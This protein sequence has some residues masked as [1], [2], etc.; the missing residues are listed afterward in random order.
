MMLICHIVYTVEKGKTHSDLDPPII[1]DDYT[2]RWFWFPFQTS[3]Q[4]ISQKF[5]RILEEITL[6]CFVSI[7]RPNE[8]IRS[9]TK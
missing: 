3:G 6:I 8:F 2:L 7:T 9:E 1:L 5:L 4:A